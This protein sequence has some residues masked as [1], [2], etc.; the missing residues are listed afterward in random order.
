MPEVIPLAEVWPKSIGRLFHFLL[1]VFNIAAPGFE[2]SLVENS[3]GLKKIQ[4]RER[5]SCAGFSG[6]SDGMLMISIE[7]TIILYCGSDL[8]PQGFFNFG[9]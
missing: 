5:A 7:Q 1:P 8:L 6:W 3:K 2:Y 4:N 9:L